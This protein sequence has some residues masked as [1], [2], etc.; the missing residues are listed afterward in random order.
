MKIDSLDPRAERYR[1]SRKDRRK[2]KDPSYRGPERRLEN[3]REM[4][5]QNI[6]NRLER[7]LRAG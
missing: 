7:E 3:R 4:V 1:K 6:I 2:S 5:I